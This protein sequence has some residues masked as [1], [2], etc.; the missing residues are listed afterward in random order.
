LKLKKSK[1]GGQ[2]IL[3]ALEV[4]LAYWDSL[5]QAPVER[6]SESQDTVTVAADLCQGASTAECQ[7]AAA[8][9]TAIESSQLQVKISRSGLAWHAQIIPSA[10]VQVAQLSAFT[11]ALRAAHVN[12]SAQLISHSEKIN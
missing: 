8:L 12:F 1:T 10:L 3:D 7:A 9:H 5:I 6:V 11:Q 2:A 4:E